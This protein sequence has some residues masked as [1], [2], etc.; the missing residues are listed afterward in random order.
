MKTYIAAFFL[1]LSATFVAAHPYLIQR[2]GIE[3]G[4]SNNYVLS[5]TQ[6]KQGFL[7]FATEEGLNKFDGTRFITYYKEEQSSSVQSITGNELNE[8]YADPVQPVI[9]IATQRAGLN[10]YNYETQSFSVYQYNPEDPQSLITNDVTHITSSVQAGKGL[11]VCTYYRGIEYLDIATGKF[12][13]YNKST[14]PALPSEQT[15]TATEA[16]DGKLYIGHVEGGLSI[17]SLNDKSVKHF[18]HDPQNPNSLPGNDVRCIYKDTNGNIWIGTS[19]GLALFNANTETFT[20]FHN[21]PGNIHGALSSYIFSIKQLKDNKL[22]I[23]TE[24]NGIM[25]LDLQQN[26]FLLPEQIR[27]EF[28][29]EGD[30]N[31][32]LSNASARYIFQDSFNNIWIGTWGGGI[33][34]ISNAPPAF[35]TWSYSPTQMNE[36]SLSNKVVSSV[37]DDGQGKLWIGTDGG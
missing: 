32:S 13:H 1:L 26:Q 7:W 18:V 22:W 23:A 2:L 29:R 11:W 20:N 25:I 34:F 30:N 36:S 10:A 4:L 5:I 9:W 15:W 31:Y 6:D 21:N 33:N 37:C 8:V 35:H 16:E 27:F 24:L 12:T 14:V 17:L 19:K 28:I 3:Q